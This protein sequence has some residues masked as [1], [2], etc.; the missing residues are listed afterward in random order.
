MAK[1]LV[2]L[3]LFILNYAVIL[4]AMRIFVFSPPWRVMFQFKTVCMIT[5]ISLVLLLFEIKTW[6]VP[7]AAIKYLFS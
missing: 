1:L 6:A 3:L 5:I 2:I 7:A 4:Y